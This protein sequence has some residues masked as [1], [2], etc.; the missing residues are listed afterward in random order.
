LETFI[1]LAYQARYRLNPNYAIVVKQDIDKLLV[2]GFIQSIEEATWLSPIIVTPKKN[3]K[4]KICINFRKLKCN[5]KKRSIPI[6]FHRWSVEH[7]S[8]V[9]SIFFL[10]WI[11]RISSNFYNFRGYIQ[12]C[13]CYKLGGFYMEGDAI[14]NEKWT[15][16]ISENCYQSIQIFFWQFYKDI[17]RWF[18]I[19]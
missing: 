8:R 17:S 2:A 5:H 19:V 4:L 12:K 13:I 7:N 11:F 16:N 9:W 15:S 1:P 18:Y 10:K 3:N 14:W 6:T